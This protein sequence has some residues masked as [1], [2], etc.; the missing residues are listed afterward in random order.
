MPHVTESLFTFLKQGLG[1]DRSAFVPSCDGRIEP[2]AAAYHRRCR[3]RFEAQ[4]AQ[5]SWKVSDALEVVGATFVQ[6]CPGENEW[7][8]DLFRNINH[9][10]DL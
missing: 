2:L 1:G 3:P 7:P 8:V 10:S 5:A 9:P 6:V 4:I